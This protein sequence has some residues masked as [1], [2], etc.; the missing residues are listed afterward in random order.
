MRGLRTQEADKFNR[1]FALVQSEAAKKNS[2]FFLDT[3][4]GDD[5]ETD[6]ME[7]E[8]LRGWLIPSDKVSEFEKEWTV[9]CHNVGDDWDDFFLWAEWEITDSTVSVSFVK[10]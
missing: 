1:F 9:D 6:T 10:Y 7:G 3:S 5:F 4:D 2:V 8:T